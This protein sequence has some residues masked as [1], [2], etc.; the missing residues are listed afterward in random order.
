M[1]ADIPEGMLSASTPVPL[2]GVWAK[3]GGSSI[4]STYTAA[5]AYMVAEKNAKAV[6][7]DKGVFALQVSTGER[8]IVNQS[9]APLPNDGSNNQPPVGRASITV[10]SIVAQGDR[11]LVVDAGLS[12]SETDSSIEADV[13]EEEELFASLCATYAGRRWKLPQTIVRAS[14]SPADA[15]SR[16]ITEQCVFKGNSLSFAPL[17]IASVEDYPSLRTHHHFRLAFVGNAAG[18]PAEAFSTALPAGASFAWV[19][20]SLL[21]FSCPLDFESSD[22][23]TVFENIPGL[24]THS[25]S[26]RE[27]VRGGAVPAGPIWT[28]A[29]FALPPTVGAPGA[30]GHHIVELALLS[31]P[32][33]DPEEVHVLLN[34]VGKGWALPSTHLDRGESLTFAARRI[35]RGAY[36]L[37]MDEFGC[38]AIAGGIFSEKAQKAIQSDFSVEKFES[39]VTAADIFEDQARKV[40]VP[41]SDIEDEN[42]VRGM[43]FTIAGAF[44]G[45]GPNARTLPP[46]CLQGGAEMWPQV[47]MTMDVNTVPPHR[48]FSLHELASVPDTFISLATK[49]NCLNLIANAS[50]SIRAGPM[51][52]NALPTHLGL[53]ALLNIDTLSQQNKDPREKK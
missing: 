7:A 47:D 40:K 50:K 43:Q 22:A 29:T 21:S 4:A 32:H 53:A 24:T 44:S 19:P 20:S 17:A 1:G 25:N 6:S 31:A 12:A 3:S 30:L 46:A 51:V 45:C 37:V 16:V 23:L 35:A 27:I 15:A 14:E 2:A 42:V 11:V 8:I 9:Y 26:L 34:R 13:A 10:I 48:W 33:S 38:V 39:E 36:G 18:L 5:D 28:G 41:T 52:A 49:R